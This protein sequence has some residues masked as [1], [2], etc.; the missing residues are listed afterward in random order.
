[1]KCKYSKHPLLFPSPESLVDD[2]VRCCESFQV[3]WL[4]FG[5]EWRGRL[6]D[7]FD[8]GWSSTKF[9]EFSP[10]L[11]ASSRIPNKHLMRSRSFEV[12]LE[13]LDCFGKLSKLHASLSRKLWGNQIRRQTLSERISRQL[14]RWLFQEA[15]KR[16]SNPRKVFRESSRALS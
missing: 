2:V 6:S 13:I 10:K 1:M 16:Q 11:E 7:A 9:F 3:K 4:F 14:G 8:W 5:D 15:C 12:S